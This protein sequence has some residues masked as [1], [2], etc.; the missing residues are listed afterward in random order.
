[1]TEKHETSFQYARDD[2]RYPVWL[3]KILDI[4]VN[5]AVETIEKSGLNRK[6]IETIL[7]AF[8]GIFAITI[9]TGSYFLSGLLI[10]LWVYLDQAHM[11]LF[12][13]K[14]SPNRHLQHVLMEAPFVLMLAIHFFT[15]GY[16]F[17]GLATLLGFSGMYLLSAMQMKYDLA[18]IQ[19]PSL[20]FLRW[21]RLGM[22][23]I[24]VILGAIDRPRAYLWP[25]LGGWFLFTLTFYDYFWVIIQFMKNGKK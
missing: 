22:L 13:D 9:L 20:Y 24:M 14:K 21:D 23:A 25:V 11:R 18:S 6:Q 15:K 7:W 10:A 2:F 12:I 3:T 4:F 8:A 16:I 19:I 5:K 17:T 1:M